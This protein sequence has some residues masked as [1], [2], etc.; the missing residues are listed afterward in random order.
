MDWAAL[1]LHLG[2][3]FIK[4]ANLSIWPDFKQKMLHSFKHTRNLIVLGFYSE[5]G[6]G[7]MATDRP[8]IIMAIREKKN[9]LKKRIP[10]ENN[11]LYF[12]QNKN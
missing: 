9:Q 12:K 2:L 4:F 3:L 5:L 7:G 10:R 8:L 11:F 1:A 6:G